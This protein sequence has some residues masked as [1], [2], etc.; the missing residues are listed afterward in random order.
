MTEFN[1]PAFPPEAPL[2]LE[3]A[4]PGETKAITTPLA[5]SF[6]E[7]ASSFKDKAGDKAREFATTG[8]DKASTFLESISQAVDELARTVDNKVGTQYGDYARK[9]ATAVSGA[10]DNLKTADVDD[11][12]VGA[13]DF[14]RKQPAVAIGAAAAVGFLL[15]RLVRAGDND[16]DKA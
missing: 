5:Q 15:T 14:V 1:T 6:K 10:A 8:K 11:L 7:Q 13:R 3:T 2:P 16:S 9:A 12:V 4:E